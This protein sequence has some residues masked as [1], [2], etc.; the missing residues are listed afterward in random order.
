MQEIFIIIFLVKLLFLYNNFMKDKSF[1]LIQSLLY[2]V[3]LLLDLIN[4]NSTYIKYLSI[5]ICFVYV[6]IN[7]KTYRIFSM[8]FTLIADFFLLVINNYYE[9][10]LLSFVVV[11]IIYCLYIKTFDNK[12][13]FLFIKLRLFFIFIGLIILAILNSLTLLNILVIIYFSNLML[14]AIEVITCNKKMFAIG[15]LLFVCCDI[16]VGLHNIY[17]D[18][19]LISYLMWFFYLPSQVLIVLA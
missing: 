15:L 9:I 6:C 13:F 14:N 19:F 2:F 4:Y 1:V 12:Y 16:N 11:Q 10:G 17:F 3:F 18:N 5:V 8:F 7:R